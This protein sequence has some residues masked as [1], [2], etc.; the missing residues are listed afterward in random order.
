MRF[1]SI[2]PR[3]MSRV[4]VPR[5]RRLAI[6]WLSLLVCALAAPVFGDMQTIGTADDGPNPVTRKTM[7]GH[8]SGV[9]GEEDLLVSLRVPE[10]PGTPVLAVTELK[11]GQVVSNV[12]DARDLR[13]TRGRFEIGGPASAIRLEGDARRNW[14]SGS[15]HG[16]ITLS[17]DREPPRTV[18]LQFFYV[19]GASWVARVGEIRRRA[20]AEGQPQ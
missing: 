14:G 3:S 4:G 9:A 13:V 20:M 1:R 8:W 2:V 7:V 17:R 5:L 6:L 19:L 12:Y 10:A 11:H 18:R 15:G 16:S